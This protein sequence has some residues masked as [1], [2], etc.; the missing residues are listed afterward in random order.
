VREYI[1]IPQSIQSVSAG[2]NAWI[3]EFA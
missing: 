1:H 3:Y 2:K